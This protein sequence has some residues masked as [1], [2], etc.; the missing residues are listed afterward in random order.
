MILVYLESW[1]SSVFLGCASIMTLTLL[2]SEIVATIYFYRP[3]AWDT[4]FDTSS[5]SPMFFTPELLVKRDSGF[6]L[7]W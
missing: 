2:I 3:P 5:T 7:L 1:S 4:H 6:G